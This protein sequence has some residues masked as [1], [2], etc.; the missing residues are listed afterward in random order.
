MLIYIRLT[1]VLLFIG[2]AWADTKTVAISYFDNTSG[3]EQYNALS[4]GLADMLITDLSNVKSIQIVEREKLETL[5]KEINL[6][7]GK[8]INPNTAQQ[9][10]KGLG[11]EYILTGAFLSIEPM[12]RIDARLVNVETGLVVKANK[13]EGRVTDFFLLENQLVEQLIRDLD[14]DQRATSKLKDSVS[15]DAIFN[16]SKSIDLFDKGYT[17][18]ASDLI[19]IILE[20]SPD[21][22]Y[23]NK[24]YQELEKEIQS[25]K[26]K[27]NEKIKNKV[28]ELIVDPSEI[29]YSWFTQFNVL[30]PSLTN[31]EKIQLFDFLYNKLNLKENEIVVTYD[32]TSNNNQNIGSYLS[33]TKITY[34]RVQE[35]YADCIA[36][37]EYYLDKYE[38]IN[39]YM[40]DFTYKNILETLEWAVEGL[41]NKKKN[42]IIANQ[43]VQ[44]KEWG[45]NLKLINSYVQY[46][47]FIDSSDYNNVKNL[48]YNWIFHQNV[49]TL[50]NMLQKMNTDKKTT[51]A[52]TMWLFGELSNDEYN[53]LELKMELD[54]SLDELPNLFKIA[55]RFD[56]EKFIKDIFLF[57]NKYI[58]AISQSALIYGMEL[59][60][61]NYKNQKTVI[62][63][64]KIKSILDSMTIDGQCSM[65]YENLNENNDIAISTS[66]FHEIIECLIHYEEHWSESNYLSWFDMVSI[67]NSSIR[68]GLQSE[69]R[70]KLFL[71]SYQKRSKSEIFVDGIHKK[72]LKEII[73]LIINYQ[74]SI[75][76]EGK[77]K[78]R[79]KISR[80]NLH[81]E[82]AT[83]Y[84]QYKQYHDEIATR[85][86]ILESKELSD[87]KEAEQ[88]YFLFFAHYYLGNKKEKEEIILLLEDK[89][90]HTEFVQ[91]GAALPSMKQMVKNSNYY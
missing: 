76:I 73:E 25:K 80:T 70:F 26:T 13:V 1:T 41:L 14:L 79:N 2:L 32:S 34:L 81:V 71:T 87:Q 83:I 10:G 48:F 55:L 67:V 45:F 66:L 37:C 52:M 18:S 69:E 64:T 16:Y 39:A 65:L 61:L 3:S 29:T 60:Y 46:S 30:I 20:D 31:S 47:N 12:M 82:I 74:K 89:Y 8:F 28:S 22:V 40:S 44:E 51:E 57:M 72:E 75:I 36:E 6:G 7:E 38:N 27:L 88:Y 49:D 24:L 5:L 90:A 9:L 62:N 17:S 85:E 59:E 78:L 4:K 19:R 53:E 35:R 54:D 11:A 42:V 21:F 43:K 50:S 58:S 91:G 56:D 63:N 77:N 23:A 86:L 33:S 15:F 84:S 68:K